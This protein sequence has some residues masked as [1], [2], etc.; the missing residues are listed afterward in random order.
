MF[1]IKLLTELYMCNLV[2][3]TKTNNFREKNFSNPLKD[4]QTD[5]A[6]ITSKYTSTFIQS[7]IECKTKKE[8][9][10]F[11]LYFSLTFCKNIKK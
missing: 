1:Y 9:K 11:W 7:N 3:D 10:I 2:L 6:A 5:A 8:N 4:L